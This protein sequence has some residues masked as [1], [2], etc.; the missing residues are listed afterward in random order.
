M[1]L[2]IIDSKFNLSVLNGLD[3]DRK[4]NLTLLIQINLGYKFN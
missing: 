3:L 4:Q 1:E 2:N